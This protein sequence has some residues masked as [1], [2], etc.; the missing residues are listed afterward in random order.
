MGKR[1]GEMDA[2]AFGQVY[3]AFRDFH[4]YLGPLLGRREWR[5]HSRHYLQA[6]LVQSEDRRNAE[7]LSESVGVSPWAMQ[8][9]LTEAAWDLERLNP[10]TFFPVPASVVFAQRAG[11]ASP[12]RPL[13]GSVQCWLGQA[14]AA[15]VRRESAAI[16]DTSVAGESPYADYTRE[17]ATIVPRCLFFVQE[18]ENTAI[19]P[20]G[21]TITVNPR[22]GTFDKDPW[23]GL[24]LTAITGQ[25]I[26]SRHVFDVHL[27]ETLVPYATL[28][29][30]KAVLPLKVGDTQ[31][32]ADSS[33]IGGI[34]LNGL[35]RQMRE[36]WRT[37]SR[38]WEE[39]KASATKLSLL[40][41]IDYLHKLSAQLEWQQDSG[42][43]PNTNRIYRS[44]QSNSGNHFQ[45]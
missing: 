24:D 35:E 34:R 36:R 1:G 40:G 4:A 29:P 3:E 14:G 44:R 38:L 15:D 33:G 41:Q 13:A 26:E 17:G 8:R 27:G 25:T 45:R 23:R 30:L 21:Q 19:I 18:T 28:E 10:N 39:N 20:A 37:V 2:A 12:A 11:V 16:T 42:I 5:G 6:L 43:R 9:F 22:R 31:L 32:P 7:N